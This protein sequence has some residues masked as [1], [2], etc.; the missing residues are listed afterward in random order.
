MNRT[1]KWDIT[2]KCG[3]RCKHCYNS[4]YFINKDFLDPSVSDVIKA[5]S[6]FEEMGVTRIH[7]LGGEPLMSLALFPALMIAKI[8]SIITTITT[9]GMHLSRT[10]AEVLFGL[11]VSF[12]A[13]SLDGISSETNDSIRGKDVFGKVV[14]NLKNAIDIRNKTNAATKIYITM[15]LTKKNAFQS[16]GV[17]NFVK[18]IG[19][20]G[21]LIATLDREGGAMENWDEIALSTDEWIDSAETIVSQKKVFPELYLEIVCKKTL[22]EYLYRKYGWKNSALNKTTD[23]CN[24]TDEEYYIDADGLIWPCRKASEGRCRSIQ[25]KNNCNCSLAPSVF[26]NDGEEV[27]KNSYLTK[28]FLFSRDKRNYPVTPFCQSCEYHSICLPCPL[29]KGTYVSEECVCARARMKAFMEEVK[30]KYI[31]IADGCLINSISEECV[32]VIRIKTQE[33][34]VFQDLEQEI[35]E[36]IYNNNYTVKNLIN[37]AYEDY[38]ESVDI[39]EF[40]K[41]IMSFILDLLGSEMISL[42]INQS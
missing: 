38:K 11:G 16:N 9:N 36:M 26:E 6:L 12:I 25:E 4:K 21:V 19:A 35:I 27:L 10:M 7:F 2:S 14:E 32:S 5:M 3:L 41:D 30:G 22:S 28:F 1:I 31:K 8:K 13:V 18:E 20:D 40:D 42:G 15:T 24:G 17:L 23:Y 33:T 37:D 39:E 29:E 34:A